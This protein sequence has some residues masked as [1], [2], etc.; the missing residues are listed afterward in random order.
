[1]LSGSADLV[2]HTVR[3]AN[4]NTSSDLDESEVA[5]NE[6]NTTSKFEASLLGWVDPA[7]YWFE[8]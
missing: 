5:E 6:E 7:L 1:M 3:G 4:L 8:S 2:I